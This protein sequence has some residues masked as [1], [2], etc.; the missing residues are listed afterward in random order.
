MAACC[1]CFALL[2]LGL[3]STS[4]VAVRLLAGGRPATTYLFCFAKKGMP[5]KATQSELTPL[6][7]MAGFDAAYK[8]LIRVADLQ[9]VSSSFV[10]ELIKSSTALPLNYAILKT[11]KAG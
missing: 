2:W 11:G 10:M 6:P 5:K 9:D 1:F 3:V 8:K 7:D 4:V